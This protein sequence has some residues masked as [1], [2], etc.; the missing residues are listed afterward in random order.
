MLTEAEIVRDITEDLR[1]RLSKIRIERGVLQSR[2]QWLDKVEASLADA[3]EY[4]RAGVDAGQAFLSFG[5]QPEEERTPIAQF[6][7][8]ALSDLRPRSLD[9]LK[10]AAEERGVAFGD[11]TPGRSLHFA[12]VGMQQGGIVQRTEDGNW[13]MLPSGHREDHSQKVMPM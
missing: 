11:K 6:L 8:E 7:R 12:L 4:E 3:L 2:L 13:R 10:R 5:V 1:Q 9:D